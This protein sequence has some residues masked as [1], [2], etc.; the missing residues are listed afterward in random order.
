MISQLRSL[1]GSALASIF[2]AL[3]LFS[4][5]LSLV[6]PLF[7]RGWAIGV[8]LGS[9]TLTAADHMRRHRETKPAGYASA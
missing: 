3:F 2:I 1:A 7:T 6:V 4:P 5:L 9:I 8:V